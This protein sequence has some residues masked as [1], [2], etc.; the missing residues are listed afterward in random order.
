G[1]SAGNMGS[2]LTGLLGGTSS[3]GTSSSSSSSSSKPGK[4]PA[5][6]KPAAKKP[7]AKKDSDTL[8]QVAGLVG[9]LLSG[10]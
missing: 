10:K 2:L 8:S 6:K 1:L 7:A 3:P 4:K 9:S 5:A